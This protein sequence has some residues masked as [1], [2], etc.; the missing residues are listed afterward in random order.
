MSRAR[1]RP[2]PSDIRA[3]LVVLPN[4]V[5]DS[6]M[7][8]PAYRVLRAHFAQA[9]VTFLI[10]PYLRDLLRGGPWM[11]QCVAW[12]PRARGKPWH[13]EYREVVRTLRAERFDA[14][15]LLPNSFRAALVAWQAGVRRRIG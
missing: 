7:A 9:R 6:V 5:G 11:D 2:I 12:P 8:T 15:I 4:W 14:A 10:Q 3:L 13:R 1:G